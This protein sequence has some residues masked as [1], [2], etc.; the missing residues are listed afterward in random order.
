MRDH[1]R[2]PEWSACWDQTPSTQLRPWA[3]AHYTAWV[4][5]TVLVFMWAWPVATVVVLHD[6][7]VWALTFTCTPDSPVLLKLQLPLVE[8]H[9]HGHTHSHMGL[10]SKTTPNGIKHL[11]VIITLMYC[12]NIEF[13]LINSLLKSLCHLSMYWESQCTV[14]VLRYNGVPPQWNRPREVFVA[15]KWG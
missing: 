14:T 13:L 1:L 4:C 12:I 5:M 8:A 11:K 15:L 3:P 6:S 9:G 2:G 10:L 7:P